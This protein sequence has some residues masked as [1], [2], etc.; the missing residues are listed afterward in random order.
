MLGLS[1]LVEG[2]KHGQH[3][4]YFGFYEPPPRLIEKAAQINIPL[5]K[6]VKSGHVELIW[7]PPL[8][9][10]LDSLAELG[11]NDV[12]TEEADNMFAIITPAL[13]VGAFAERMKFSA[14][15]LF[16]GLWSLLVYSPV[17]HWVW[18]PGG[19]LGG[20]EGGD[21]LLGSAGARAAAREPPAPQ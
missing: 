9:H 15:M 1:F 21:R 6:Y 7:Q 20:A 10:M 19:F 12:P 17:A 16:V 18:G 8:E 14:M 5:E 13:I 3:G 11:N 2:A 4:I